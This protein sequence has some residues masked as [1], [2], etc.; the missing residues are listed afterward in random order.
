MGQAAREEE[1]RIFALIKEGSKIKN[2]L[3]LKGK[4]LKRDKQVIHLKYLCTLHCLIYQKLIE[5]NSSNMEQ[6]E[7]NSEI[8][9]LTKQ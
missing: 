1:A 3:S 4:Q 7:T 6:N 5:I 8:H 2:E 9:Y